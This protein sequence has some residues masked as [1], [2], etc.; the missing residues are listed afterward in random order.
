MHSKDIFTN[1]QNE[2]HISRE[3]NSYCEV[4]RQ[5][6]VFPSDSEL[7]RNLLSSDSS[8]RSSEA[9]SRPSTSPGL[10]P[11][12]SPFHSINTQP[13]STLS[14]YN[15]G[16]TIYRPTPSYNPA[17][18]SSPH[19]SYNPYIQRRDGKPKFSYKRSQSPDF[20]PPPPSSHSPLSPVMAVDSR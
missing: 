6:Q 3:K 14:H 19:F 10:Q 1:S 13:F 5:L 9:S 16:P 4:L 7:C 12:S 15:Q 2:D 17:H 8:E 18:F 11:S 20:P